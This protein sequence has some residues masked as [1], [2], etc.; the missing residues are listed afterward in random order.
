MTF[1]YFHINVQLDKQCKSTF[2]SRIVETLPIRLKSLGW[3]FIAAPDV[4]CH[5][6][7][8]TP[9]LCPGDPL[10]S[11][12]APCLLGG[13]GRGEPRRISEWGGKME[14]VTRFLSSRSEVVSGWTQLWVEAPCLFPDAFCR[15]CSLL[16]QVPAVGPCGPPRSSCL[17]CNSSWFVLGMSSF[18]CWEPHYRGMLHFFFFNCGKIYIARHFPS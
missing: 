4:S 1:T 15:M 14:L 16:D 5:P 12:S 18:S 11:S 13:F 10:S 3:P 7:F 17:L 9:A 6:F 2:S 8:L